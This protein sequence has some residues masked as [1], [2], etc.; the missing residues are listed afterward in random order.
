M[1][2]DYIE[3][4]LMAKYTIEINRNV[5][6][7]LQAGPY[8]GFLISSTIAGTGSAAAQDPL[9]VV[10]YITDQPKFDYGFAFG[11]GA[12]FNFGNTSINVNICYSI[13]MLSAVK[14]QL[15]NSG[16][17]VGALA[18][19][20]NPLKNSALSIMVGFLL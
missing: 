2:Y 3:I 15:Q 20:N 11:G 14:N 10:N 16:L 5:S 1:K 9:T 18:A 7:F 19:E 6:S 12:I 4:P 17:T 13:G 8:L